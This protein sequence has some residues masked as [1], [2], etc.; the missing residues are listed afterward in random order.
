MLFISAEFF[1]LLG[2]TLL[3]YYASQ[4]V[5]RKAVLLVACYGFYGLSSVPYLLLL[6]AAATP[7]WA[8]GQSTDAAGT[9]VHTSAQATPLVSTHPATSAGARAQ[10]Q[11]T[12]HPKL[13]AVNFAGT[14]ALS[15]CSGSKMT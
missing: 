8:T 15:N 10:A 2:A 3:A 7:A 5:T 1:V 12:K 14:V 6:G 4:A 13:R 11:A 9:S